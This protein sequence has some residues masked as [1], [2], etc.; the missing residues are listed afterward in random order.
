MNIQGMQKTTLLDFPGH[1]A[2]TVFLGGCNFRCPFCHN[3]N[4]VLSNEPAV[5]S[6]EDIFLFLNKRKGLLDGVCITGGEPTLYSTLPDFIKEI[7]K[8]GLK[9]KLD[10]NGTNPDMIDNLLQKN[11]IDY[12]AMDIKSS[13][14]DYSNITA[15]PDFNT[16]CIVDSIDILNNFN[17]DHEFRTTLIKE[18]HTEK[19]LEDIGLLLKGS[20]KYF[21]QSFVDSENVPNHTLTPF[22]KEE[23]IEI[24]EQFLKYIPLVE[25]R[26]V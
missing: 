14:S 6:I 13:L 4:I 17:I 19:V 22:S 11:L 5:Y 25:I 1:I 16:Q 12:V 3:M 26:G 21:L 2:A 23:L 7:K 18:Y 10:T 20:P 24:R 9:V 15:I 8:I